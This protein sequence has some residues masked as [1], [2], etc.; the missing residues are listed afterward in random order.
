MTFIVWG[1]FQGAFMIVERMRGKKGLF[2]GLPLPLQIVLAN[3]IVMF[4]WALFRSPSI[5]QGLQ[6]WQAMIGAVHPAV[7][8]P[9]LHAGI[10]TP[11]HIVEM[12]ICGI[13][14][15]QGVQAHEWVKRLSAPKLVLCIFVFIFAVF[16]MF[17]QTYNPFLYFQ[18]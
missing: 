16:A 12:I 3:G 11:R 4:S 1:I 5:K 9:L 2:H 15:W 7:T 13:F 6:Y 18:F 8:S 10:F 17:T 14:I